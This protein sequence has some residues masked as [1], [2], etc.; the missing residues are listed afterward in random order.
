MSEPQT[1]LTPQQARQG[2]GGIRLTAILIVVLIIAAVV[3]AI[4]YYKVY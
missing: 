4:L 1:R 2:K 3:G